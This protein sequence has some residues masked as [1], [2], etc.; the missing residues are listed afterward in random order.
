MR[1]RGFLKSVCSA[2]VITLPTTTLAASTA[3]LQRLAQPS[4]L[5]FLGDS[6]EIRSLGLRYR[7]LFPEESTPDHLVQAILAQERLTSALPQSDRLTALISKDFALGHTIQLNGWI[8][9]RTEARQCALF[10][11]VYS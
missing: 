11:M 1:R 8:L 3:T 7:E 9:S 5:S 2:L 6:D 10:S 4:L